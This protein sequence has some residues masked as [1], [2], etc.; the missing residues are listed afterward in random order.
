ML[1]AHGEAEIAFYVG[2]DVGGPEK[3]QHACVMD[4][5]GRC[6][7]FLHSQA[8]G[9]AARIVD[10]FGRNLVVAIDASRMP[11]P[12]GSG[13]PNGTGKWG[14]ACER[15]VRKLGVN[16]QW[17][18]DAGFFETGAPDKLARYSWM[19]E[20]FVLF[21][22]FSGLVGGENV[23]EVFPSASYGRF[24]AGLSARL[25]LALFGRKTKTDQLDA[26]CC[27]LTALCFAKGLYR[28][29]G[30]PAEGTIVVPWDRDALSHEDPF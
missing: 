6:L 23:L 14:R 18:P 7:E 29:F 3:G 28:E 24:P 17:T 25:P 11:A 9:L 30:D 2:V 13:G 10:E 15:E 20:G 16:P 12:V 19:R 8:H 4:G 27:A 1:H 21:R 5:T 22:E 26:A